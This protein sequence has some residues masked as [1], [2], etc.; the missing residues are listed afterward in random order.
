MDTT[1]ER[2]QAG[3]DTDLNGVSRELRSSS[4]ALGMSSCWR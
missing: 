1:A 3:F 4:G 2:S